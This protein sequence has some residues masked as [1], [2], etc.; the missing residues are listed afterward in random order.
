[1]NNFVN[2]DNI[3]KRS[4]G[5]INW[6]ESIGCNLPFHYNGINGEI[7]ILGYIPV[8]DSKKML[9]IY[10]DGYTKTE[11]DLVKQETLI[12]CV[13]GRVLHK[14]IIDTNPELIEYFVDKNDANKYSAQSNLKVN[15]ICPYCGYKKVHRISD[16]YTYGFACPQCSDNIS[17]PNK[18]MFSLLT[19]LGV[20]FEN[21]VSKCTP[22]FEWVMNYRYDFYFETKNDKY[23]VEMDGNFHE[24][25]LMSKN[26][27]QKDM[28][29]KEHDINI[30]RID[31]KYKGIRD[32]FLFVKNNILKSKISTIFD[33]S[34]INWNKCNKHAIGSLIYKS[35]ELFNRYGYDINKISN[36]MSITAHTVREYLKI[37]ADIG[38]CDYSVDEAKRIRDNKLKDISS[39]RVYVFKDNK[40]ICSFNSRKEASNQS[41]EKLGKFFHQC[42]IGKMCNKNI[43][44]KDGFV[45]SNSFTIQN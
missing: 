1:M 44:S 23:F 22:G 26:D 32:R 7:K 13:L 5:R 16:L 18:F 9:K 31:C 10:I 37:S 36:E 24:T 2:F 45:F 12:N 8:R 3:P 15:M 30:I 17:Y 25:E 14:K 28:L 35:A 21:E 20:N 41:L 33:L 11:Y 19:Q 27:T 40:F 39:K 6:E 43:S 4:D 42:T 34:E 29:A 38:L